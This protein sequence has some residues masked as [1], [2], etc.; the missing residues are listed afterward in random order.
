MLQ[1]LKASDV[2]KLLQ[3]AIEQH[4]DL[5]VFAQ[6][7]EGENPGERCQRGPVFCVVNGETGSAPC[8]EILGYHKPPKWLMNS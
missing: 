1:P 4:G 3:C 8:I 6:A 5:A 7:G 2:I